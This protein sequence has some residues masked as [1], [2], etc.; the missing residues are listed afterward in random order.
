MLAQQRL[1]REFNGC[2]KCLC[3]TGEGVSGVLQACMPAAETLCRI[4]APL[5]AQ[6]CLH[7]CCSCHARVC[8]SASSRC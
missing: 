7:A 3:D 1:H 6:T 2:A 4:A 8:S 5:H